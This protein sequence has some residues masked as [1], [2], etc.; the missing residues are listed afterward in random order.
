MPVGMIRRGT[1]MLQEWVPTLTGDMSAADVR[2]TLSHVARAASFE[3]WIADVEAYA[4]NILGEAGHDPERPGCMLT[5]VE[6]GSTLVIAHELLRLIRIA[7]S[8]IKEQDAAYAAYISLRIGCLACKHD[9]RV[10]WERSALR[11]RSFIEGPKAKRTDALARV[12]DDALRERGR[13]ASI[14]EV[15]DHLRGQTMIVDEIDEQGTIYWK[16]R[17]REKETGLKA[18]RNRLTARRKLFNRPDDAM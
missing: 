11:G 5:P 12:I 18:F 14:E 2:D 17:G 1:G 7:R 6:D 9:L 16:T 15:L 10:Q 3:G 8:A 13:N 4:R